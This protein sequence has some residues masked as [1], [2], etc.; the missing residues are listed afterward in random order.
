VKDIEIY[1]S[2]IVQNLSFLGSRLVIQV[3]ANDREIFSKAKRTRLGF[4]SFYWSPI[5]GRLG[6]KSLAHS[7]PS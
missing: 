6:P 3:L 7:S 2:G 5:T 1:D 4:N